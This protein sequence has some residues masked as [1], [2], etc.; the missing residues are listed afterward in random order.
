MT[1]LK[2][3]NALVLVISVIFIAGCGGTEGSGNVSSASSDKLL[4]SGTV[5]PPAGVSPSSLTVLSLGATTPVSTQGNYSAEVYKDG[6]AVVAAMPTGKDFGLMN[7][8]ATDSQATGAVVTAA[9]SNGAVSTSA[10]KLD[11]KSTAVSLVFISPYFITNDPTAAKTILLTIENDPKVA[12]LAS[13]IEKVFTASDPWADPAL[14]QALVEAV[15]SVVNTLAAQQQTAPATAI[16][17]VSTTAKVLQLPK[18]SSL[19]SLIGA[20]SISSAPYYADQDYTVVK[21]EAS[22]TGYG[23]S[24]ESRNVGSIDWNAEIMRLDSAQFAS[25]VD[26]QT[27]ASNNR[28]VYQGERSTVLGRL[29]APAKSLFRYAD[30]IGLAYDY[31]FTDSFGER[32]L[33]QVPISST[34]DGVY[35]VRSYSGAPGIVIDPDEVP[36]IVT[37]VPNGSLMHWSSLATNVVMVALDTTSIFLDIKNS[38]VETIVNAGMDA[39]QQEASLVSNPTVDDIM[40]IT[41]SVTK[42]MVEAGSQSALKQGFTNMFKKAGQKVIS[43]VDLPDKISNIGKVADRILQMYTSATP[44]ETALVVVGNPFSAVQPSTYTISGKVTSNGVGLS[45]VTVTL[46]G[47]AS[48]STV[49]DANGSYVFPNSTNGTYSITAAKAGYNFTPS[50]IDS[51]T[52]NGAD[53]INQNFSAIETQGTYS[54]SGTI[55]SGSNAG[56][57]LSGATV[58]IAGKIATTNSTGTFSITGI[59]SG[60]Y[61]FSVSKSG[62][63]T[64]TNPAYYIGSNQANLNFY[65]TLPTSS[66]R[67]VVSGACV[68]DKNTGLMWPKDSNFPTSGSWDYATYYTGALSLCGYTD[69]RLPSKAELLSLVSGAGTHPAQWLNTQGFTSVQADSYWSYDIYRA[70]YPDTHMLV[71]MS[72][73]SVWPVWKDNIHYVWA[74]R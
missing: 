41:V 69:W 52:V 11:A 73:G 43:F 19:G 28:S 23:I 16:K 72:N 2:G 61:A 44:M 45:G 55:H 37:Q 15:Q 53:V 22:G 17:T 9:S 57:A 4:V 34:E 20:L 65:L 8:L 51:V 58:S 62:Y 6:V 35:L 13:V 66:S 24:V 46:S 30:I 49:T 33:K 26:F 31:A 39:F 60:T 48:N 5:S 36:F 64:Y 18:K 42:A 10:V 54:I 3:F 63:D 32:P 50:S 59:P 67:F 25:F 27:K 29:N 71:D 14:Q 68:T 12:S 56:P 1:K 7:V 21:A 38:S 70:D 74:V 47:T 40:S